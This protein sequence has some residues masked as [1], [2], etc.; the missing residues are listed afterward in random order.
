MKRFISENITIE[1]SLNN[2]KIP[3]SPFKYLAEIIMKIV[4]R[5][6]KVVDYIHTKGNSAEIR[7]LLQNRKRKLG[8]YILDPFFLKL[9]TQEY[10][11][12]HKRMTPLT[13][14][15]PTINKYY[16]VDT[17]YRKFSFNNTEN[18]DPIFA[19]KTENGPIYYGSYRS[20]NWK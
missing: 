14:M 16:S 9:F 15:F 7:V 8:E 1:D 12:S 17:T 4:K 3:E 10:S 19:I 6:T 13:L 18:T 20:V 5:D 2:A 11:Y